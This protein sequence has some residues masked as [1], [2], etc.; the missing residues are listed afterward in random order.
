MEKY[1]SSVCVAYYS[2]THTSSQI[3]QAIAEGLAAETCQF[4]DLT[5]DNRN[6]PIEVQ[7]DWIVLAAPV[8]GGRIPVSAMERFKRLK[9]TRTEGTSTKAVIAVV[10]GN[11]DYDDALLELCNEAE[12]Q[13]FVPVAGGAFIGEHSFSRPEMPTA[14]NRPD[15]DDL[16]IA[17]SFGKQAAQCTETDFTGCELYVKGKMPYRELM[18]IPSVCPASTEQCNGCGKCVKLCP[19]HAITLTDGKPVTDAQTCTLCCA[20]VKM[21]PSHARVFNTPFTKVLFENC[22]ARKEPELFYITDKK[23]KKEFYP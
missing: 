20:C 23:N 14:P 6:E 13:G 19:V 18:Q 11:R 4:I 21:C 16:E 3:A 12:A 5:T 15:S 22:K 10:Y 1:N 7:A 8:Y 9:M 2:P 17:R